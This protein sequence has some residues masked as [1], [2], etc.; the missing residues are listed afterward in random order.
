MWC[1]VVRGGE[2]L[3]ASL[4]FVVAG[5]VVVVVLVVVA[6]NRRSTRNRLT[7][8]KTALSNSPDAN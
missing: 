5:S 4:L 1:G 7:K 8:P 3:H 2:V 6:G